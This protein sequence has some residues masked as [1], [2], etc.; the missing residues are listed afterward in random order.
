MIGEVIEAREVM[1]PYNHITH[2]I[3]SPMIGSPWL[4][5]EY[6]WDKEMEEIMKD[7]FD[8]QSFN[9]H[10]VAA[11]RSSVLELYINNML[12][13]LIYLRFPPASTRGGRKWC[14]KY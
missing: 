11:L 8:G 9:L 3:S 7:N 2:S 4:T 1:F 6:Y 10:L 13:E 14:Y 5:A 12:V